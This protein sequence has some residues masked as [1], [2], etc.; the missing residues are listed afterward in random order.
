MGDIYNRAELD[1]LVR[2]IEMLTSMVTS[3]IAF[4]ATR[5]NLSNLPTSATGLRSG[6][7]WK[8][9]TNLEIVP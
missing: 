4:Q 6:D 1:R 2:S 5:L 9:G 3:N 8:N 7:V